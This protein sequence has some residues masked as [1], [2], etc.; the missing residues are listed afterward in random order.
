M[1]R[2]S[3]YLLSG[4]VD[5]M[6]K[7]L[8]CILTC[9]SVIVVTAQESGYKTIK[10]I[11]YYP[12]NI[13]GKNGYTD[14][15]CLLNFYYPI[16]KKDF[17][18]IVW[19]HGGSITGGRRDM[20]EQLKNK[21]YAVVDVEYRLSPKVKAPVYIED[22]AAAIA[23]VFQNIEKYG[24]NKKLVFLTGHS[25]GGYLV[26]MV[27]Y[28]KKYLGKYN[29]DAN[30][31]AALIPFSGQAITHFTVRQERGM[32]P[33]EPRIDSLAPLYFV[34]KD[35]PPTTL[36]TGD[37]NLELFGR[38]EENAYLWRM[39]QL[40]GNKQ[41]TLYELQGYDHGNMPLGAFP[42]LFREMDK[43][44]REITQNK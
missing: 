21:G 19:F 4:K 36:I 11:R 37:R 41:T 40:I 43:R 14:S 39:M 6:K 10:D 29:I 25:A 32:G 38:Y 42:I 30:E 35:A 1:L 20:P 23:W 7:F 26:S 18:T 13:Y 2:G 31:I 34:R 17:A 8:V 3:I 44:I 5:S 16:D 9:F 15:M 12:N 27:T 28:D 24:G 33:L 22:A